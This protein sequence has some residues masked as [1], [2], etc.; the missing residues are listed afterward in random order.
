MTRLDIISD[1][2]CPWCHV[3]KTNLETAIAGR[4]AHPFAIQWRA[5]QLDPTIPPE[6]YERGP[7]IEA[8]LGGPEKVAAAHAR[9]T[10]MGAAIGIAFRFDRITRAPNTLDAH[11]LTR[12]AA[13]EDRQT[14]V[15]D[16]LFR[17][18]F[19]EGEDISDA[20]V[21]ADAA[22]A[23]GLDPA[24]V[25]R[26]LAG[27]SDRAEVE[28]EIAEAARMGVAGV[29]TFILG[30]RYAVNGAQA[31]EVWTR[32]MDELDAASGS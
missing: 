7:Y 14:L 24:P 1:F 16:E 13:A 10:E 29:P 8:R 11:R 3:G 4:A 25:A 18:Y 26:L 17:R 21:L 2:V 32:V 15:A 23:A 5:Y 22:R 27:D 12:W 28:A 20:G 19:E 6:G 31:P 30:G 9:L